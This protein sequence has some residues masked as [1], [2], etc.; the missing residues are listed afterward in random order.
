MDLETLKKVLKQISYVLVFLKYLP[1]TITKRFT[2]YKL[3]TY[4]KM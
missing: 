4:L 3:Y 1:P 2:L